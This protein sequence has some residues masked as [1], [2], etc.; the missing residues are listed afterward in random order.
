MHSSR[1]HTARLHILLRGGGVTKSQVGGQGGVGWSDQVPS[2][3]G[4]VTKSQVGGG[5]VT[6]SQVGRGGGV[7]KSQVGGQGGV[8]KSQVGG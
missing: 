5:G 8:T 3:G 6:N 7:T 4:G 1:M 2:G